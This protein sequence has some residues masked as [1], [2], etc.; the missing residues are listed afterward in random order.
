[1]F[2]ILFPPSQCGS[3]SFKMVCRKFFL[4]VAQNGGLYFI[5]ST[6]LLVKY[7]FLVLRIYECGDEVAQLLLMLG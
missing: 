6:L 4:E 2:C 1:M 7:L 3:D 5:F